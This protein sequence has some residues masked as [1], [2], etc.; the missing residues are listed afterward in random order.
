MGNSLL[1]VK[2]VKDPLLWVKYNIRECTMVCIRKKNKQ[3]K[4]IYIKIS[5]R[6]DI[7]A[8]WIN[9]NFVIKYKIK[10]VYISKN[11][12]RS[13]Y[14]SGVLK[15][16]HIASQALSVLV[17]L[18]ILVFKKAI[19]LILSCFPKNYFLSWNALMLFIHS[20]CWAVVDIRG[21]APRCPLTFSQFHAL[22]RKFWQKIICWRPPDGWRLLLRG[23]LDPPLL[24]VM[25]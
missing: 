15:T 22:F 19:P 8:I 12:K 16:F 7:C 17:T 1:Q 9:L 18:F 3:N 14:K 21:V 5:L 4:N 25:E 13:S 11:V 24:T 6:E 20:L 23:I 10:H 2:W